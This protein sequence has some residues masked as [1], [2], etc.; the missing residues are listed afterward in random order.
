MITA[1]ELHARFRAFPATTL[2]ALLAPGTALILAP[3]QDDESLGCGG[4]IAACCDAGR[5]PLLAFLTDGAGSHP[6]SR[7]FPPERLRATR[8]TEALAAAAALGLP[9]ARVSFCRAPDTALALHCDD[10]E[11]ALEALAAASGPV[12][13]VLTTWR[14][15]PHCDHEAAAA[16]GTRLAARLGARLLFYPVWGWIVPQETPLPDGAARGWRLPVDAL[17][18]RKNKAIAAHRSQLGEVITDDP[19]GFVLPRALLRHFEVPYEVFLEG[20]VP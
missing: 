14:H 11:R 7:T 8:E 18:A 9:P 10:V 12:G 6:N 2:D 4:L 5:P 16:I 17:L 20:D 13:T 1:G 3:H 19:D 15:D